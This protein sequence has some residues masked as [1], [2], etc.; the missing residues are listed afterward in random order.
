MRQGGPTDGAAA[1]ESCARRIPRDGQ[2]EHEVVDPDHAEEGAQQATPQFPDGSCPQGGVQEQAQ[3]DS[4]QRAASGLLAEM[5][6]GP[7]ANPA[8]EEHASVEI[9][10]RPA[11]AGP[12][13]HVQA[14][15][16]DKQDV[17]AVQ[18]RG[19]LEG[20]VRRLL[21]RRLEVSVAKVEVLLHLDDAPPQDQLASAAHQD[22]DVI[23][24]VDVVTVDDGAPGQG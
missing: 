8:V 4:V 13:T 9:V 12:A 16:E 2:V 18:A 17:L 24:I 11:V 6:D 5:C 20:A 10:T 14:P 1:N 23:A 21:H 7:T 3:G 22:G 19:L 15:A